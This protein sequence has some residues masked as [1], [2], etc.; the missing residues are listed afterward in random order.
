[1]HRHDGRQ[2]DGSTQGTFQRRLLYLLYC[3]VIFWLSFSPQLILIQ[4][5]P[6][7]AALSLPFAFHTTYKALMCWITVAGTPWVLKSSCVYW[8]SLPVSLWSALCEISW[9]T[10]TSIFIITSLN[11]CVFRLLSNC[12]V[13]NPKT[14]QMHRSESKQNKR[15]KRHRIMGVVAFMAK[16]PKYANKVLLTFHWVSFADPLSDSLPEVTETGDQIKNTLAQM[17]DFFGFEHC[18]KCLG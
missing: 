1:M 6:P 14:A 2:T 3:G 15:R 12:W 7:T 5:L 17:M 16:Q 4:N 9:K 8:R 13:Q 10:P 11:D 18:W